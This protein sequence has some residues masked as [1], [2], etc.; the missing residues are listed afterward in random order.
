MSQDA[1]RVSLK[2]VLVIAT[3]LLFLLEEA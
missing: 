2:L 1:I 3:V